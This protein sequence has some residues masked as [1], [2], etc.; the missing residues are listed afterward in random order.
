MFEGFRKL[1]GK[2]SDLV[3]GALEMADTAAGKKI[4]LAHAEMKWERTASASI[5]V[6]PCNRC[7]QSNRKC[8]AI[9]TSDDEY[10]ACCICMQC[11]KAIVEENEN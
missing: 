2:E 4:E 5:V 10:G 3:R 8:L 11:L 9:D 7:G 1:S 6:A